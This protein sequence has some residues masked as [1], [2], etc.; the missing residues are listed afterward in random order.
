MTKSNCKISAQEYLSHVSLGL[1]WIYFISQKVTETSGPFW[2]EKQFY[3]K[4]VHIFSI[5]FSV[6]QFK[7]F[8]VDQKLFCVET[9]IYSYLCPHF[10]K[11]QTETWGYPEILV[12]FVTRAPMTCRVGLV[13]KK[14]FVFLICWFTKVIYGHCRTFTM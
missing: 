8:T 12:Q 10:L 9:K 7:V 6:I 4:H 13:K 3:Y 2:S 11:G 5:H 14:V 1:R